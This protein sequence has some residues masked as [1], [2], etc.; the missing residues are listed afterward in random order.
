MS[1]DSIVQARRLRKVY[2]GATGNL[3]AEVTQ[4][5]VELLVRMNKDGQ[6]I[7]LVTHNPVVAERAARTLHI[8]DGRIEAAR[9]LA[10][11]V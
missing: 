11:V 8:R 9:E 6:T 1:T 4:V 5:I 10:G 7:V 2:R 3:D